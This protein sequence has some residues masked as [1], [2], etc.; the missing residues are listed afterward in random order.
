MSAADSGWTAIEHRSPS[1]PVSARL[2]RLVVLESLLARMSLDLDLSWWTVT[3][4][5]QFR[6]QLADCRLKM[7]KCKSKT[8]LE[9]RKTPM[10]LTP[11][12][13]L[14]PWKLGHNSPNPSFRTSPPKAS[15]IRNPVKV[16]YNQILSGS[17]LAS[18]GGGLGRDDKLRESLLRGEGICSYHAEL[19]T[20]TFPQLAFRNPQYSSSTTLAPS[21]QLP[22]ATCL[23]NPYAP[24]HL[25]NGPRTTDH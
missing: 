1:K 7:T 3:T 24:C 2:T 12:E 13:S 6:R 15:E 20:Y 18:A 25:C 8:K 16:Q 11:Q 21:C 14:F 4:L 10:H 19:N 5:H 9:F 17:R 23:L 22:A